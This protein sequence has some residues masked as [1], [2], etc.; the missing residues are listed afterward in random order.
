MKLVFWILMQAHALELCLQGPF[1]EF[2]EI[3]KNKCVTGNECLQE[4]LANVTEDAPQH[5]ENS[6]LERVQRK[7]RKRGVAEGKLYLT[8]NREN[9]QHKNVYTSS[10]ST[11]F[12]EEHQAF[13]W[14]IREKKSTLP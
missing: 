4:L 12:Q 6:G 10:D 7:I 2:V 9:L 1:A 13:R 8:R 3:Q 5:V 11:K 14:K